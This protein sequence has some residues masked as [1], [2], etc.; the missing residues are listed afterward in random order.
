MKN[1]LVG[2]SGGPTAAINAT[3]AGVI[4]AGIKSDKIGTVYG[5]VNGIKGVLGENFLNLSEIYA[6]PENIDILKQTP[7]AYLGSCRYKLSKTDEEINKIADILEKHDIGYFCYIGGNDSMDTVYRLKDICAKKGIMVMGV[8]K[9]IDN[10]LMGTDHCP[11]FGS[12]AKYIATTIA[13]IARD[14]YVYDIE[15][16][17][18]VEIMG[19]N[20]GWLTAAASLARLSGMSAPDLI[21]L[22]E[23]AF[24]TEKFLKD[25][26]A[27]V[28]EK[29][30]VIVAVSEGIKDKDGNYIADQGS[31]FKEDLFGHSQ[32]GGV[33]KA[34]ETLV[35]NTLKIKVRSIELNTP[36]RCAAHLTSKTDIEESALIGATAVE[37]ALN[38]ESGMMICYNRVYDNPYKIE[39]GCTDISKVANAE[40]KI[41]GEFISPEGN[42]VT[43][44]F[45]NYVRPLI[46]G[47]PDIKYQDGLP[48]HI[49]R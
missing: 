42:D 13:E 23:V 4:S 44:A 17:A 20:A 29:T 34:L 36:Q 47:E 11:G 41:P 22:P 16:V 5:A 25:V 27:K 2:Q 30:S 35:K 9:T 48:V 18:I 10:D 19:R 15:S 31:I 49:A 24:D 14:A 21:Y 3:L 7:S 1:L 32:L 8:P 40:K 37:Y 6:T 33:G 46:I 43:E 28:K 38:G 39:I 12:A 45:V 26:E